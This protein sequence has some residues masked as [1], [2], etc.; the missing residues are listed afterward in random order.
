MSEPPRGCISFK[1]TPEAVEVCGPEYLICGVRVVISEGIDEP[2]RQELQMRLTETLQD[3]HPTLLAP[4]RELAVSADAMP[5][6]RPAAASAITETGQVCIWSNGT[7][8]GFPNM[9]PQVKLKT[10][11]HECAHLLFPTRGAPDPDEW[12][13]AVEL[14]AERSPRADRLVDPAQEEAPPV[15]LIEDFAYIVQYLRQEARGEAAGFNVRY[16]H[17]AAIVDRVL[18]GAC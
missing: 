8:L 11:E 6:G 5:S 3:L 13:R 1:M 17:R 2:E 18:T 12:E 9:L 4:L 7:L 10:I 14:D 16:P 15:Q